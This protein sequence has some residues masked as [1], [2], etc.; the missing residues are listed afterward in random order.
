MIYFFHVPILSNVN[1][2]IMKYRV[3]R[4]LKGPVGALV[5]NMGSQRNE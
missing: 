5:T 1:D 4:K 3:V 2:E